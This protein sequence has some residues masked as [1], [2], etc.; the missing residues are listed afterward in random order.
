MNCDAKSIQTDK[1]LARLAA[2]GDTEAFE[3]IHRRYRRLVYALA[4]RMTGNEADAEDLTQESFL[5]VLRSIGSFRGEAAF[6]TWLYRLVTNQVKMHFRYR[7]SRPEDQTADGKMPER[8]TSNGRRADTSPVIDRL[9]IERAM[10]KLPPGYRKAFI[11]HDVKGY[12]H[13]EIAR[14]LRCKTGTSKSQ[15]H[16]AR[17]NLRELLSAR[18]PARQSLALQP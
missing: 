5:S 13:G 2:E 17:V 3:E 10:R 8:A 15:L 16:K 9:A 6:A 1:E 18:V 4:L 14:L 12:E 7:K 11:L